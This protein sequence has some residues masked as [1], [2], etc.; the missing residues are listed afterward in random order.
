MSHAD[1]P[2]ERGLLVAAQRV[3][4]HDR[5]AGHRAGEVLHL[6]QHLVGDPVDRMHV[7]DE[8]ELGRCFDDADHERAVGR[9]A[10]ETGVD[11]VPDQPQFVPHPSQLRGAHLAAVQRLDDPERGGKAL[12]GAVAARR[13][14]VVDRS[15][16]GDPVRAEVAVAGDD[17]RL[18][19]AMSIHRRQP[20]VQL[21]VGAVGRSVSVGG[22]D[23][24]RGERANVVVA[25]DDVHW[26]GAHRCDHSRFHTTTSSTGPRGTG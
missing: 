15:G 25:V 2:G 14:L 20:Q 17:D 23:P 5:R 10:L 4:H 16:V 1:Q 19:D 26:V 18:V 13:D 24:E 6:P 9:D 8:P 7:R 3:E 11:A 21:G 22:S 12:R